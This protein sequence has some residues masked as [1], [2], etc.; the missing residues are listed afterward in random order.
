MVLWAKFRRIKMNNCIFCK[1][2]KGEIPNFKIYEDEFTYAFLDASKDCYGHTLVIP[3]KH[4]KNIFDADTEILTHLTHT[5]KLL[6][7]HYKSL[8]FDGINI[9]NNNEEC[10]GQS[11]FH[12]H[13]HII[14]RKTGDNIKLYNSLAPQDFDLLTIS[15]KLIKKVDT[16]PLTFK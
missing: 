1:I 12:L 13:I 2:A 6:C 4:I 9:L 16:L 7:D 3:K 15:E 5:T 14:P 11:V 10:A 8:G